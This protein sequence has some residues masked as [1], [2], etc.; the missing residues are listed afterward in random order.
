MQRIRESTHATGPSWGWTQP[1]GV[2]DGGGNR[3]QW[4]C[5]EIISEGASSPI[6]QSVI[7]SKQRAKF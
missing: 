5:T 4:K 3:K 1:M 2:K 7:F 6:T